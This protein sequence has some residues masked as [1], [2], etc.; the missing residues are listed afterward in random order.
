MG[1]MTIFLQQKKSSTTLFWVH[2]CIFWPLTLK[3][4]CTWC[5]A[6]LLN[7]FF[8]I[9]LLH[10]HTTLKHTLL[11]REIILKKTW[12]MPLYYY[13]YIFPPLLLLLSSAKDLWYFMI[14]IHA[15][16]HS[17][18]LH[19][20]VFCN[21]MMVTTQLLSQKGQDDKFSIIKPY[22]LVYI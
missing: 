10:M 1:K 13:Y 20:P 18:F 8:P 21:R 19:T 11:W 17:W 15:C 12:K 14:L 5:W 6:L 2:T 16:L 7:E 3:C 4:S 22:F 9:F